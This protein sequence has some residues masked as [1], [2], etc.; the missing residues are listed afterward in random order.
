MGR[1]PRKRRTT[2]AAIAVKVECTIAA[3]SDL[4]RLSGFLDRVAPEAKA[5]V[6][7]RLVQAPNKLAEQPRLGERLRT[8]EPREVRRLV[9]GNY[10]MRDEIASDTLYVLRVRHY[11]EDGRA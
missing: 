3:R 9:I 2:A 11:R 6:V 10:E 5:R 1:E 7:L 8:Y 4:A